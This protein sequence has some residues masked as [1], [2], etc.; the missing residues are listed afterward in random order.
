MIGKPA[1]TICCCTAAFMVPRMMLKI[2]SQGSAVRQLQRAL[3]ARFKQLGILSVFSLR[4]DGVFGV[5]TLAA[6][7]YLQCVGGLPVNGRVD[8]GTGAFI[9]RGGAGLERLYMGSRGT[10]VIA[11][12][13]TLRHHYIDLPTEG[14]F[15]ALT[16]QGVRIYQQQMELVADGVVGPQTWE[17]VVRSRLEGLPCL[18]LRPNLYLET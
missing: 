7:K 9:T 5:E 12:Q 2:G 8:N 16:E 3:N 18:A 17:R 11:V 1:P 10:A 15:D 4:V 13:R 6:V 14:R